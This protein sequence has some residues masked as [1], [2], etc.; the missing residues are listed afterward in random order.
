M[1]SG[2]NCDWGLTEEWIS[3]DGIESLSEV[4]LTKCGYWVQERKE[5]K[6]RMRPR[7][8]ASGISGQRK[9]TVSHRSNFKFSSV[10][11]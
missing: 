1:L 8:L 5:K 7:M 2:L 6:S 4:S 3:G 9:H 10:K 11:Y